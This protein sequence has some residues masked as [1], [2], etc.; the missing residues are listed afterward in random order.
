MQGKEKGKM[1]VFQ[2]NYKWCKAD[3]NIVLKIV[4]SLKNE[5]WPYFIC[6]HR[7]H[8]VT[9]PHSI[10]DF[11][12]NIHITAAVYTHRPATLLGTHCLYMVPKKVSCVYVF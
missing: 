12:Q 11:T 8:K 9:D 6:P 10:N 7:D 3:I 2:L 1:T 4:N 5:E